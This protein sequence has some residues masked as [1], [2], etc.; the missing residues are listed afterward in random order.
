MPWPFEREYMQLALVAAVVVGACAPLIGTFVVQKHQSLMG[1]GIGHVAFAGVAAGALTGV[2]PVWTALAAAVAGA[3]AVE[4]LRARGGASGDLALA[5]CFYGGI[6]AGAVLLGAADALDA[7]VNA[8]LFGQ[9]LTVDRGEALVVVAL[10]TLIVGAVGLT[11]RALFAMAVDEEWARVA[12]VPVTALN[13][14]LAVLVAVTVVA[15]M[16]VVGILLVAALM[17]LPVA[18]GQLLARSQ[19]GILGWSVVIGVLSGV[20]G[21]VAARQWGLQPGG[22]IVLV[23]LGAYVLVLAGRGVRRGSPFGVALDAGGAVPR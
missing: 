17:V 9:L 18:S 10:G 19:R 13:T 4:W 23:A 1:D 3:L 21:L 22:T 11:S 20:V 2:W 6:A 7:T 14:A 16:R 15:S 12:G 5:V 8:Y